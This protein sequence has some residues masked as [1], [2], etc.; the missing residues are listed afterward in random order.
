MGVAHNTNTTK[1]PVHTQVDSGI[2]RERHILD[3]ADR[4]TVCHTIQTKD[5]RWC[6]DE[7]WIH[8][9]GMWIVGNEAIAYHL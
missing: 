5:N 6:T 9:T 1:D 2:G 4:P 8:L 3:T 7:K